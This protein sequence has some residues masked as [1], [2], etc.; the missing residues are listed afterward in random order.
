MNNIKLMSNKKMQNEIINPTTM[1]ELNL[2]YKIIKLFKL[3]SITKSKPNS[4]PNLSI[5]KNKIKT[6]NSIILNLRTRMRIENEI[7]KRTQGR[8]K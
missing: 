3:R 1:L 5:T 6:L 8:T 7:M 2:S 4:N